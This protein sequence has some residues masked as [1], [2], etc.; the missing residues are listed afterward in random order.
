MSDSALVVFFLDFIVGHVHR[1]YFVLSIIVKSLCYSTF[2]SFRIVKILSSETH[3]YAIHIHI[4]DTTNHPDK[5][6]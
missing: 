1:K 4:V 3:I 6:I 5:Y 2:F